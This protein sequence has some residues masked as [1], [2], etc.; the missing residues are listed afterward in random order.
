MTV[1]VCLLLFSSVL[2]VSVL[3]ARMADSRKKLGGDSDVIKITLLKL[4]IIFHNI[5]K[6]Q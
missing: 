4:D 5:S 1:A 2:L 3:E 6:L